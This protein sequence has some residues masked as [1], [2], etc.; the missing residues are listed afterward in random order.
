MLAVL[1]A[2]M[3]CQNLQ[4]KLVDASVQKPSNV[5]LYF[6]VDSTKKG[7]SLPRSLRRILEFTKM[8]SRSWQMRAN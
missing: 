8:S 6:T 2:C 7:V 1:Q 4:M 5:V 3:G